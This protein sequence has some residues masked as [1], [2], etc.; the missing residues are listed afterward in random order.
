MA[1]IDYR[2]REFIQA[3]DARIEKASYKANR[4]RLRRDYYGTPDGFE[5]HHIIPLAISSHWVVYHASRDGWRINEPSQNAIC[6]PMNMKDSEEYSLPCHRNGYNHR[7][8]TEAAA[9]LL[10][11]IENQ[12]K[13]KYSDRVVREMLEDT[14]IKIIDTIEEMG[15]GK[16]IDSISFSSSSCYI[17]TATLTSGGSESQLNI[18]RAWR[19][20]VLTA[21]T[22]G[23]NLE[24]F[25]DRTGPTVARQVKLNPILAN[26]FLYPFVKPAIW[27]VEM[28]SHHLVLA[29][30]FD[31]GIYAIFL[32]GL[33]YGAI[34]YLFCQDS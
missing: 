16:Y 7:Y 27:L 10:D 23:R 33:I 14:T 11:E 29:P 24:A 8:Y 19:D 4:A 9:K 15:G 21:T 1:K 26:S 20:E 12:A 17:A 3:V 22:F 31:L 5:V 2:L 6:L 32:L 30:L 18:L 25:Y 34:V 13:D 28:R